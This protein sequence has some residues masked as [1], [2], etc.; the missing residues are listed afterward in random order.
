MHWAT[1]LGA[2]LFGAALWIGGWATLDYRLSRDVSI[3]PWIWNHLAL[4]AMVIIPVRLISVALL[5]WRS[6]RKKGD[7]A[8]M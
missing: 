3:V 7:I 8:P 4:V 6:R 5:Y 2:N 1:F